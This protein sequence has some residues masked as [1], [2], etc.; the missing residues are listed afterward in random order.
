MEA[1]VHELWNSKT[2]REIN[3]DWNSYD[4]IQGK[5]HMANY[6]VIFLDE[7][8]CPVDDEYLLEELNQKYQDY[9]IDMLI[10]Q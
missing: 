5:I 3:K 9:L 1:A 6:G 7:Y 4:Q 8:G 10:E 2:T